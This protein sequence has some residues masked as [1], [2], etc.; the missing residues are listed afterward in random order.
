MIVLLCAWGSTREPAVAS[1]GGPLSD[2]RASAAAFRP[3]S[4]NSLCQLCLTLG[5]IL[6]TVVLQQ[7]L[8]L[9]AVMTW[10]PYYDDPDGR[11]SPFP[12]HTLIL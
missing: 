8:D 5:G 6:F 7:L 12:S 2:S 4:L 3:H 11:I 10:Q 1:A 9:Q